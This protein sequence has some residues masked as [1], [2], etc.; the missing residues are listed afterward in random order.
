[1]SKPGAMLDP[2]RIEET[3]KYWDNLAPT[4]DEAPDHGL[5]DP[6]V[7]ESWTALLGACLPYSKSTILDVGCGTGSLSVVLAGLGHTVTGIDLSSSMVSL[8]LEKAAGHGLPIKFLVMDASSPRLPHHHFDVI[9]C[10]HLLWALPKPE[11]V[12][13]GWAELLKKKGRLILIEGYWNTGAGLH[14]EEITKILSSLSTNITVKNLSQ[15]PG[16]WGG[17]VNDERYAVIADITP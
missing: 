3:R 6:Q 14:A 16:L 2:N 9:V 15:A 7:L 5:R 17:N 13:R 4:F 8:A 1:M 11:R 12:L 10:R